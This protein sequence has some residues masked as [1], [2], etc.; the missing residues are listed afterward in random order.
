MVHSPIS[1]HSETRA[2]NTSHSIRG[3]TPL[4]YFLFIVQ[5]ARFYLPKTLITV[6]VPAPWPVAMPGDHRAIVLLLVF[7]SEV[8]INI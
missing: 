1:V 6:L 2:H 8:L 4:D 3:K 5:W 7:Q